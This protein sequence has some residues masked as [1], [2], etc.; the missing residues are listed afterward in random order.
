MDKLLGVF[1][2]WVLGSLPSVVSFHSPVHYNK[3][4]NAPYFSPNKER[5]LAKV[6][7]NIVSASNSTELFILNHD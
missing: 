5:D 3:S 7:I 4:S 2:I 6:T 1:I